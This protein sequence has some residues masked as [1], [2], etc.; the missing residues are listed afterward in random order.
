MKNYLKQL[1]CTL[2]VGLFTIT[3][4]PA[5]A[6]EVS[7]YKVLGY[8]I[9][10]PEGNPA[11]SEDW[12]DVQVTSNIPD[13]YKTFFFQLR[14]MDYRLVLDGITMSQGTFTE[15]VEAHDQHFY[16][17]DFKTTS[18]DVVRLLTDRSNGQKG[19]II[20]F[21]KTGFTVLCIVDKIETYSPVRE[22][23]IIRNYQ[24]L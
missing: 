1:L 2:L 3:L 14:G 11:N 23:N 17:Y 5:S 16:N 6:Q 21:A 4:N 13:A 9:L 8:S 15:A 18:G 7:T 22:E 10:P 20:K 24:R 19:V 12:S